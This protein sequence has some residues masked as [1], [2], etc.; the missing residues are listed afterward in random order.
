MTSTERDSIH[1]PGPGEYNTNSG[2]K[3]RGHTFSKATE[4][5]KGID[6]LGPGHYNTNDEVIRKRTTNVFI[7]KT[8][9]SNSRNPTSSG[10]GPGHYDI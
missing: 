4:K 5:Q 3:D 1:R 6:H 8:S 9:R 10:L 7:T 2:S